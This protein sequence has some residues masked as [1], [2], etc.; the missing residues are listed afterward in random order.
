MHAFCTNSVV[1]VVLH[2]IH[3][4]LYTALLF[5][6]LYILCSTVGI[7]V[8]QFFNLISIRLGAIGA[9]QLQNEILLNSLVCQ[10]FPNFIYRQQAFS[11][12]KHTP[13]FHIPL[14]LLLSGDAGITDLLPN[15]RPPTEHCSKILAL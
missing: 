14:C 10:F 5:I 3:T 6:V 4:A 13:R 12:T 7:S 9:I 2:Y 8:F 1:C 15:N 11:H